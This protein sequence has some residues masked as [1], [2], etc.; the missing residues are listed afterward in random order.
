M[1][2]AGRCGIYLGKLD[3]PDPSIL[4]LNHDFKSVMV[5]SLDQGELDSKLPRGDVVLASKVVGLFWT[6]M[7]DGL[8]VLYEMDHD[9]LLTFSK[10]RIDK[11]EVSDFGILVSRNYGLKLSYDERVFDVKWT[12]FSSDFASIDK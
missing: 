4:I 6:P 11:N 7:R 1:Q 2:L 9:N 3:Y 8:A 5:F 12:G 10:N